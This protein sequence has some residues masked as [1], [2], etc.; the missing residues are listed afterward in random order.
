M[1]GGSRS[2][3]HYALFRAA[4]VDFYDNGKSSVFVCYQNQRAHFDFLVGSGEEV[5]VEN[6]SRGG[7]ASFELVVVEGTLHGVLRHGVVN[8]VALCRG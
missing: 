2:H 6:L 7:F 4:V 8:I 5:L 3:I 1:P